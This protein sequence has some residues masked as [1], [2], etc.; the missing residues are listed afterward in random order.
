MTSHPKIG[1][2]TPPRGAALPGELA[3]VGL[4]GNSPVPSH[5]VPH[6]GGTGPL[7]PGAV[8]AGEGRPAPGDLR[9]WR[10]VIPPGTQLLTL[11]QRLHYIAQA[12]RVK[13]LRET[14]G[15]LARTQRIPRLEAAWI[16]CEYIAPDR[17][18]RDP[19][20]WMPTAKACVD[21]LVDAGVLADDDWT[22]V[23]GPDMRL[24]VPGKLPRHGRTGCFTVCIFELDA[25]EL[26]P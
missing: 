18:R 12:Q 15:W 25:G 6:R 3:P 24:S 5:E 7:A 23:R 14:A 13:T 4:P 16:V 11:N 20:N 21:G 8:T 17:R 19:G 1:A 9:S 22:H 2:A 10:I 26:T